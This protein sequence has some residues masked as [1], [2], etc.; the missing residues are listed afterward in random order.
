MI[1][2]IKLY[3]VLGVIT[4]G[5]G[6]ATSIYLNNHSFV[7]DKFIGQKVDSIYTLKREV[8]ILDS[9][10]WSLQQDIDISKGNDVKYQITIQGLSAENKRLRNAEN[11]CCEELAHAEQNGGII[12]DTVYLKFWERKKKK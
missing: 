9:L 7:S 5:L 8:M 4:V 2:K 10:A 1:R 12:R 11:T 3:I 6:V